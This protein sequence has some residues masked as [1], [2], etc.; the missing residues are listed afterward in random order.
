MPLII[1]FWRSFEQLEHFAREDMLHTEPWKTY[2]KVVGSSSGDV[3][4]WHETFQVRAGEYECIYGN[5]PR[6]GLA[7]AGEHRGLGSASRARERIG[8]RSDARRAV[9]CAPGAALLEQRRVELGRLAGDV[10]PVEAQHVL[11]GLEH[12]AVAQLGRR[13]AGA[14]SS[15]R[16]ARRR[17]R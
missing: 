11:A 7:N 2:F 8:A 15:R 4:I 6:F 12:E 3:G 10:G 17:R 5:M 13:S 9:S 16:G 1:Q 14:R